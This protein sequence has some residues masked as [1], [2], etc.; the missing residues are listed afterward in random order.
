[1]NDAMALPTPSRFLLDTNV[2]VAYIRG[3]PLGHWIEQRYGLKALPAAPI[4]SVVT[5]GELLALA[6]QWGWGQRKRQTL[7]ALVGHFPTVQLNYPGV[8]QAYAEIS[9][10][11]RKGRSL[12]K[13]DL[14]IA[15]TAK[16]TNTRLLTTDHDFD[17]LDGVQL[18]RDYIDPT[19]QP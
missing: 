15:A 13:N 19:S 5:E 10:F 14:W 11:C 2:L 8:L 17:P 12:G 18:Y 7:R 4:I 6:L 9:D 1:M 3:G 16:A